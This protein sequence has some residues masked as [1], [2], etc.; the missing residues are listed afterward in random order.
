M[1]PADDG[2]LFRRE[3]CRGAAERW[4]DEE[5]ANVTFFFAAGYVYSASFRRH[6][7]F[8]RYLESEEK[9]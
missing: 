2:T 5:L 9:A 3:H 8:S 1:R 4:R 6:K 7:L